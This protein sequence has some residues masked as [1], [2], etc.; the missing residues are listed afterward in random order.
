MI[1]SLYVTLVLVLVLVLYC[2]SM[3]QAQ[4]TLRAQAQ[5]QTLGFKDCPPVPWQPQTLHQTAHED[6]TT[7]Q[8]N[9]INFILKQTP[10]RKGGTG[11][12]AKYN[13]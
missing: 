12:H 9:P 7:S 1:E 11:C 6:Q 5:A 3:M 13:S 2:W 10:Y 4:A 8:R